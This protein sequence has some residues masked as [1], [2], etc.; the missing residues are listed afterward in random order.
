AVGARTAA[1]AQESLEHCELVA[2]PENAPSLARA[3]HERWRANAGGAP[4]TIVAPGA[5]DGD[6]SLEQLSGATGWR[7]Q[8]IALYRTLAAAPR[9]PRI[10][11]ATW[12]LDAVLLAS[13]SAVAGLVAQAELPRGLALACIGPS[14]AAAAARIDGARVLEAER[15]DL[16]ALLAT[17]PVPAIP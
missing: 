9:T 2:S 8:R 14:T 11:L 12:C 17:L 10:D 3:L 4:W 7:V 16:D 6:R 15:A 1:Q 5:L 13:P